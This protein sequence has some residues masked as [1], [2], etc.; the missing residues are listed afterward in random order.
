MKQSTK[1]VSFKNKKKKEG[2]QKKRQDN[3]SVHKTVLFKKKND[4]KQLFTEFTQ[5]RKRRAL[6]PQIT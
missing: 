6:R 1:A 5:I 3:T 2:E 4:N